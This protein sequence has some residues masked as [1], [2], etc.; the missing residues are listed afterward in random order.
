MN[1]INRK[2]IIAVSFVLV[3]AVGLF[4]LG[5]FVQIPKVREM[6]EAIQ[7]EKLD[8]FVRQEKAEKI[9]KLKKELA[10]I[11][12][13]KK[14]MEV[15]FVKKEEAVPFLRSLEKAA[16]DASSEIKVEAADL[17]K[18]KFTQQKAAAKTEDDEDEKTEKKQEAADKAKSEESAKADEIAKLKAY[19]AF[20][21]EATGS[22][23]SVID[24]LGKIEN[25]PYFIRIL[26]FEMSAEKKSAQAGNPGA[27]AFAAGGQSAAGTQESQGKKVKLMLLVIVYGDEK[28]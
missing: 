13:Q 6:S 8:S 3:L 26:T 9:F 12:V 17:S 2:V 23:S 14:E 10:D 28:K 21:I 4:W 16:A 20:N 19:P 27:G 5:F 18:V 11:E 25:L 7:K 1:G 24:F 22:F 15:V